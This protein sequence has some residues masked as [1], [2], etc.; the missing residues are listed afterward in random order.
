[1]NI[2]TNYFKDWYKV[3]KDFDLRPYADRIL[4]E[5]LPVAFNNSDI[6]VLAACPNSGKTL[7]AIAWMEKYLLDNPTH[8]ILVLTHGQSLLRNQFYNDIDSAHVDFSY[9]KVEKSKDFINATSQVIVT[10]PRTIVNCLKNY[11]SKFDVLIVDEAHH[12]YYAKNGMVDK[13][14]K[15]FNFP[16]QL[17]LTGTPAPFIAQKK[18][19]IAVPLAELIDKGYASDPIVVISNAT[20]NI[21][22]DDFTREDELKSSVI[23]DT[24]STFKTLDE[25][26]IHIENKI[27]KV[28][29]TN[30]IASLGKTM[31]FTKDISQAKDVERYFKNHNIK[32][33]LSTSEND[34]DSN[35]IELFKKSDIG[36]LIVVD[37]GVLGFNLPDLI[38][39]IDLK[40][41]KNISNLFQLFNRIT[42]KHPNNVQKYFFKV[43]PK[44]Y[45][46]EYLYVLTAAL[47]LMVKDNYIKYNGCSKEIL[48]PVNTTE[49]KTER[50]SGLSKSSGKFT[51]K[52]IEYLNIP[53]HR[54]WNTTYSNFQWNKLGTIYESFSNKRNWSNYTDEVNFDFCVNYVN[55]HSGDKNIN[56]YNILSKSEF[57]FIYLYLYRKGQVDDFNKVINTNTDVLTIDKCV[58][59]YKNDPKGF[60]TK[61]SKEYKWLWHNDLM[62]EFN[63]KCNIK[64]RVCFTKHTLERC[65]DIYKNDPKGFSK[66]H[67][68][69]YAWLLSNDLMEEFNEK[70]NIKKKVYFTKH[71][72]ERCID[73]Y[74]KNPKGFS[75]KYI[76][77]YIW[78]KKGLKDLLN[79]R[80]SAVLILLNLSIH[81]INV[82]KHTIMILL[83]LK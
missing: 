65:I 17:L 8:R 54:M 55:S 66:K 59:I 56:K 38:C 76:N 9:E 11:Q 68:K 7:M 28:G 52:P 2:E 10:L 49:I 5:E 39:V 72:L 63:K 27:L 79:S 46:E 51:F 41:G 71:T 64:K 23:L 42:R 18:Q 35:N 83:I 37:R 6:A 3:H 1:M 26:L 45:E 20:Y 12:F 67:S 69:E 81:L 29:W 53:I 13:I 21:D 44:K 33:L 14:I 62:E 50:E 32:V 77:E 60:S 74:K 25:L 48:I 57:R 75:C 78:L 19:I 43:V 31:I 82:L 80:S 30:S 70:C 22:K 16:K 58:E 24:D 73:I 4:N 15:H 47:S 40:C 36:I 61:H 34:K